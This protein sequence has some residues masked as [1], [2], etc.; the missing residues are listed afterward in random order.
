VRVAPLDRGELTAERQLRLT[1]SGEAAE[2][3]R[4]EAELEGG[5][6]SVRLVAPATVDVE[7]G[8][9]RDVSLAVR[10]EAAQIVRSCARRTVVVSASPDAGPSALVRAPIRSS[11]PECGRF[12]APDSVWNRRLSDDAAIDPLSDALVAELR[13]QVEQNYQAGFG[14]EINAH[15]Y[16][17]PIYTVPKTQRTTRVT[18]DQTGAHTRELRDAFAAVPLPPEARPAQGTD[19]HLVVWQPETDTMWE[20]W[21]LRRRSDRWVASWGGRM[22]RV[23]RN[24][25]YFTP[26]SSGVEWGATGTGLPLVGGLITVAELQ[27]GRIEHAL[28]F[29]LPEARANVWVTPAQ[30]TDGKLDSPNAIPEGARFR[31]DPALN[32]NELELPRLTRLIAEAVQRYGMVLRDQAGVVAFYG[33]DPAAAGADPYRELLAG[34][35]AA[36]ALRAFPWDRLQ[37]LKM[38]RGT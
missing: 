7:P 5:G 24:R 19:R 29:A 38:R 3:I 6:E 36:D 4:L 1:V 13:R 27:Q 34:G 15:E 30:R 31:L 26:T 8:R 28:A 2:S 35:S 10:R 9:P 12:F 23:S 20:F 18:V 33:E 14:P 21:N 22:R 32:L 25:G 11:P 16:G 17:V 37:L